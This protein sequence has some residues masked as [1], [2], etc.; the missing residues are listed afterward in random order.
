MESIMLMNV[1]NTL[2]SMTL[3][4]APPAGGS[5][6]S[7]AAVQIQSIWDLVIKG[8]PMMIPIGL[9]SLVAVAVII[10]RVI[11]L[12]R[13]SVLPS[14]F[15][16]GL[17]KVM[18]ESGGD[19]AKAMEYCSARPSP[20]SRVIGAAVKRLGEPSDAMERHVQ[21]AGERE[22]MRLRKN[23]RAL[24]VV[25]AVS[26]LLG[27]LGTIFGMILAFQ[28]VAASGEALGKTE[29]LAEG[30]YQAMITT[31]AG[32]I[33]AIPALVCYHWLAAKIDGLIMRID[34]L[35]VE[36]IED[37]APGRRSPPPSHEPN[38]NGQHSPAEGSR[39]PEEAHA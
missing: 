27:L 3:A 22:V 39:A 21:E 28:T 24:S 10:E 25:A 6:P 20:L 38:S 15:P 23:L 36:F 8:G 18:T 19:R 32:L 29:M 13:S 2:A 4:S 26:P 14:N 37:T 11:T 5:A 31:A 1:A 35:T 17:R 33:V 34:H 9:C 12:R 16:P 30:I 7:S